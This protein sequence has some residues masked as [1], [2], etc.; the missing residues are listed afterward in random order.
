[1]NA[2]YHIITECRY[3]ADQLKP[4]TVLSHLVFAFPFTTEHK[5]EPNHNV[6]LKGCSATLYNSLKAS[7]LC[8]KCAVFLQVYQLSKFR[9][10]SSPV[11]VWFSTLG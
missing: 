7:E 8:H 5:S 3:S 9:V 1:L 10:E 2:L 6:H 4:S 11:D